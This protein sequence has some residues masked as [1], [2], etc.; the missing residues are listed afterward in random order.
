MGLS[1]IVGET[2]VNAI[3]LVL[4]LV[5]IVVMLEVLGFLV[6]V[7]DAVM[8]PVFV[9]I[10]SVPFD[11]AIPLETSWGGWFWLTFVAIVLVLW[12]P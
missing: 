11:G 12:G 10:D 2:V 6:G 1:D 9:W 4:S 8:L 7:F 5:L 3:G